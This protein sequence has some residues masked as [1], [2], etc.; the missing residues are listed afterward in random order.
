MLY[1]TLTK[2]DDT[3]YELTSVECP[4]CASQLTIEIDGTSVYLDSQGALIQKSLPDLNPEVRERFISGICG[5]CWSDLF[6][7]GDDN[8]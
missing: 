6:G 2:K 7:S 4:M 1:E 3:T 5:T 8:E